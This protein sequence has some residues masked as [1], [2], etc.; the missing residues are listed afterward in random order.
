MNTLFSLVSLGLIGLNGLQGTLACGDKVGAVIMSDKNNVLVHVFHCPANPSVLSVRTAC[1]VTKIRFSS[2]QLT[3]LTYL[4]S[5]SF[6]HVPELHRGRASACDRDLA[7]QE[8]EE[9]LESGWEAG[10]ED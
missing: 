4:L 8:A 1:P 10:P 9:E 6:R 3:M 7:W 5:V 2:D